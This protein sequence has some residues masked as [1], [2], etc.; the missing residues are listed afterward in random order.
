MLTDERIRE[1][2]DEHNKPY[3]TR[4]LA[5]AIEVEVRK[6]QAERIAELERQL[7]W[8]EKNL[9]VSRWNGVIDSGAKTTWQ[10]APEGR[11]TVAKMVGH[12]FSE[13][14]DASIKAKGQI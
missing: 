2:A 6:E 4:K 11:H 14:I 3:N 7:V 1:L 9:F 8:I 5:R 12:T 13:A 10:I